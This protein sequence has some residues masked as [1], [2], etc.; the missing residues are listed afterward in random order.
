MGDV[1][2]G[3]EEILVSV[4]LPSPEDTTTN[5]ST[6]TPNGSSLSAASSS[7]DEYANVDRLVLLL[8]DKD[9]IIRSQAQRIQNLKVDLTKVGEQ[10]DEL[11]AR[12]VLLHNTGRI[13]ASP[14]ER[15]ETIIF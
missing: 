5:T 3:D 6:T 4:T 13:K 10:R 9:R 15:K 2:Y 1:V 8:R 14:S 11:L 12:L 7:N